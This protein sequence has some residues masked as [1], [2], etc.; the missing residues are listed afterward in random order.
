MQKRKGGPSRDSD[1]WKK[2]AEN[3][4]GKLVEIIQ[5]LFFQMSELLATKL[6]DWFAICVWQQKQPEY[7]RVS[8]QS[9]VWS[10]KDDWPCFKINRDEEG[11][12]SL[13]HWHLL[14][15]SGG[16]V[17]KARWFVPSIP[18]KGVFTG[19]VVAVWSFSEFQTLQLHNS[20]PPL[21]CSR[22]VCHRTIAL[23]SDLLNLGLFHGC[24]S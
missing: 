24:A 13:F 11:L 23:L 8:V 17:G 16:I 19:T 10:S 1:A 20:T 4:E 22:R 12:P 9:N 5:A 3:N 21:N 14:T 15:S 6:P 18:G 7:K 2:R